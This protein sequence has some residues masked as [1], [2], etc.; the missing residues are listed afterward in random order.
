MARMTSKG[1]HQAYEQLFLRKDDGNI[2]NYVDVR[3]VKN[4]EKA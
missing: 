3:L 2:K 4:C 1:F